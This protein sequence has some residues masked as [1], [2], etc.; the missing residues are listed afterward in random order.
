MLSALAVDNTVLHETANRAVVSV[1]GL[2]GI[3]PVRRSVR[4]RPTADGSIDETRYRDESLITVAGETFGTVEQ[5]I[6]EF[7]A[8]SGAFLA[9]LDRP[10]LLTW[11]EGLTGL[12]LQRTVKLASA[13]E[14]A[15]SEAAG[16]VRYG[17]VLAAADPA[18]YSQTLT[19]AYGNALSGGG[20]GDVFPDVFPD[21]FA[22][23][24][25]GIAAF[26]NAGNA[27][28][29]PLLRIYGAATNPTVVHP[30]GRRIA[31]TGV[32]SDGE[33]IE[34]DLSARTITRVLSGVR[35]PAMNMLDPAT[36]RWFALAPGT[37]NL[38]LVAAS[39][40]A[41]AHLEISGRS[42]YT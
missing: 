9:T 8:V 34:V 3:S 26:T 31:L 36:T 21:V 13:L 2:V 4:P 15:L 16:I 33:Y 12:A 24:G 14:P 11:T 5:A 29:R 1:T 37:T 35:T 7:R 32:V 30:D 22:A 38:Q 6:A 41:G 10:G 20:G 28:T 17:A 23:S 18:A 19:T 39:F 40:D 25:G 27:P 42:A